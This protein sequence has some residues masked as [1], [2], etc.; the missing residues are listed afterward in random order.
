MVGVTAHQIEGLFS[1]ILSYCNLGLSLYKSASRSPPFIDSHVSFTGPALWTLPQS[2]FSYSTD[3]R[4]VNLNRQYLKP[5]AVLHP[6][7][8]GAKT[9]LLYHHVHSRLN[10]QSPSEHQH[11]PRLPPDAP[12]SDLEKTN[13]IQNEAHLGHTP[14]RDNPEGWTQT[15]AAEQKPSGM[16]ILPHQSAEVAQPAADAIP[17]RESGVAYYVDL[18]GHASKRGCFMYGNSFSDESTQVGIHRVPCER[19]Q[20]CRSGDKG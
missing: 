16:W 17:P 19:G 9:V 5:D 6:A 3:S 14:D 20:R 4:G 8:Y 1:F 12:F 11:S 7:I 10:S 2:L 13:N 15:E 18:H